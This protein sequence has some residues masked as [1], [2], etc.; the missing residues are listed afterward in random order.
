MKFENI[1]VLASG[2]KILAH[3]FTKEIDHQKLITINQKNQLVLLDTGAVDKTKYQTIENNNFSNGVINVISQGFTEKAVPILVTTKADG[4]SEKFSNHLGSFEEGDV[5]HIFDSDSTPMLISSPID[6]KPVLVFS[7]NGALC[8][9]KIVKTNNQNTINV[10][11]TA[12]IDRIPKG[13]H[14][15]DFLDLTGNR[16]ADLVLHIRGENAN[17]VSIV[18]IKPS[19]ENTDKFNLNELQVVDLPK[20]IGPIIFT[21]VSSKT[22]ADMVFVSH[23]N[24]RYFLNLYKNVSFEDEPVDLLK[25]IEALKRFYEEKNPT[26]VYDKKAHVQFDL[27]AHLGSYTP[28]LKDE[29]GVP[30]GIFFADLTGKGRKSIFLIANDPNSSTKMPKSRIIML[31]YNTKN[32][33]FDIQ[34]SF[35][36]K[37]QILDHIKS[38]TVFDNKDSGVEHLLLN[39]C[40]TSGGSIDEYE[41]KLAVQKQEFERVGITILSRLNLKNDEVS[42]I[43][44]T[45]FILIYENEEE[46]IK[47]NLSFQSSYPS[48]QKHRAF[49]GLGSTNLFINNLCLW[50]PNADE[51]KCKVDSPTYLVPNTFAV[52]TFDGNGWKIQSFFS[53]RFFRQTFVSLLIILLIF[54]MIYAFLC[55]QDKKKYKIVMKHDSMKRVFDTL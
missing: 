47:S 15:S 1:E 38:I 6:T 34:E 53:N 19:T 45:S 46:I 41:L 18:E 9:G 26:K 12:E 29:N 2:F 48:L 52:L 22:R 30:A 55:I 28:V 51:K 54:V 50:I 20:D 24:G 14:T 36:E 44:G 39:T 31:E 40:K 21:E 49:E 7:N 42:F 27:T 25:D 35:E 32:S 17:Q 3:A 23:E 11:Q 16:R 5:K 10:F 4:Q 33:N 13:V 8:F 43:L 37:L